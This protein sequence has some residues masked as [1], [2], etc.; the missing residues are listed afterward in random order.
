MRTV[1]KC[2]RKRHPPPLNFAYATRSFLGY[3]EGTSKAAHT[4]KNY[5][6]DL[7][8][9]QRFL[10]K[11]LGSRPVALSQMTLKDL[12]RY[13]AYLRAEGLKTNT[14]RRKILTVRRLLRYL[15]VRKKLT[16][17]LGQRIPAPHKIE[18][19]PQT[20]PLLEL[21]ERIRQLPTRTLLET[22]NRALLWT[23]AETGCLVSEVAEL[24]FEQW[25][26]P[27]SL[28]LSGKAPRTVPVSLELI[29]AIEQLKSQ[30]QD[31][32]T[33]LFLGFNRYGSLGGAITPRGIELLVRHYAKEL[34]FPKLTPR[35]FRH[36]AV[37]H[38]FKQGLA[39][40]DIQ[41]RLGLKTDYAFRSYEPLLKSS[42]QTT[43][44]S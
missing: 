39:R 16:L 9:F 40:A 23:L 21:L 28:S 44:S 29:Q 3:L 43:S 11:G 14:R 15:T 34:G 32:S 13:H 1:P 20:V 5:E 19:T 38:W 41:D 4:I 35:T 17:D 30:A 31:K 24:R 36:S 10:E 26:P 27:T 33:W 6:G 2:Q 12:E 22:R 18:R 7:V 25:N 37:I 8:S 42:C